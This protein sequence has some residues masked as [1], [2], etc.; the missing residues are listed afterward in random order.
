M[1][2]ELRTNTALSPYFSGEVIRIPEITH[3]SPIT[4]H[5]LDH[6]KGIIKRSTWLLDFTEKHPLFYGQTHSEMEENT[7]Q[8]KDIFSRSIGKKHLAKWKQME[9]D[10]V[11][12]SAAAM[13][14]YGYDLTGEIINGLQHETQNGIDHYPVIDDMNPFKGYPVKNSLNKLAED[15][16]FKRMLSLI[17]YTAHEHTFKDENDTLAVFSTL[18]GLA[19]SYT[20]AEAKRKDLK[21]Q[22]KH[23]LRDAVLLYA[24]YQ[25]DHGLQQYLEALNELGS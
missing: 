5:F 12:E 1:N 15:K 23:A 11:K 14:L 3:T 7:S 9:G 21:K 20:D 2:P 22:H 10:E 6:R 19:Q 17:K 24:L 13:A 4:A 16:L 18:V 8:A 25:Y